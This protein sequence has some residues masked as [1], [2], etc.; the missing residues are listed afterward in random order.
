MQSKEYIDKL[1]AELDKALHE[2]RAAEA[3][4][5][6]LLKK[7]SV[8]GSSPASIRDSG[9][10]VGDLVDCARLAAKTRDA[11]HRRKTAGDR[12]SVLYEELVTSL[13]EGDV[14]L[15]KRAPYSHSVPQ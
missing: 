1:V 2:V 8:A 12:F 3:L 14:P 15:P 10:P 4:Y 6:E 13:M 11:D 7:F 9:R 5:A